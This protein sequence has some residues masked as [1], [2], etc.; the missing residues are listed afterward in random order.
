MAFSTFLKVI[1]ARKWFITSFVFVIC[2]LIGVKSIFAAK[3]YEA[4]ASIIINVNG[5][6]PITGAMVPTLMQPAFLATQVE[7]VKSINVALKVVNNLGL[8]K[9]PELQT[10]FAEIGANNTSFDVWLGYGLLQNLQVTPSRQSSIIYITYF[11][12]IKSLF[13]FLFTPLSRITI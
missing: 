12:A 13:L 9:N 5:K 4:T 8:S 11:I 1:W 10:R 6:D 7:I 2:L 3:Q